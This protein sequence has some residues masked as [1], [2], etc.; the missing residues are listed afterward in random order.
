MNCKEAT[1]LMS[2][3]ED[4]PLNAAERV[5]LRMHLAICSGCS[6][7]RTQMEFLRKACGRFVG[8][9]KGDGHD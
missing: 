6:N 5:R 9:I 3:S 1:R 7:F 2:E 4:R 8:R